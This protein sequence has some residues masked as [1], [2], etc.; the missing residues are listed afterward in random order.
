MNIGL[1]HVAVSLGADGLGAFFFFEH[2]TARL[3]NEGIDLGQHFLIEVAD[4]LRK[5]FVVEGLFVGRG[6]GR[7]SQNLTQEGVMVG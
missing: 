6:H 5:S 1:Q 7:H 2:T 4:I 3:G